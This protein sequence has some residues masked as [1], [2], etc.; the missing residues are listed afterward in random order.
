M[1]KRFF[2]FFILFLFVLSSILP[3]FPANAQSSD[4][5]EENNSASLIPEGS[6]Y[7]EGTVLVTMA[8][9]DGTPLA[10]EGRTSFDSHISVDKSYD[11]G[12][13]S[14]FA[15]SQEQ[16]DFLSDKTLYV[17]ELSSS[18]Y[19]TEELIRKMEQKAYVMYA[20]PDYE[21]Y[22]NTLDNDPYED[23]Q[24]YLD[25][26]R[27]S[28]TSTGISF[29]TS[30]SKTKS[31]TP[32]I[33]IMDTGIDY[34]HED[35]A[36][37]M[38]VNSNMKL[39]GI[40]GYDFIENTP[41]CMD[42]NG[43]GTHCAGVVA[44]VSGNQKGISGISNARLMALKIFDNDGKTTNSKIFDALNYLVQAK[45]LGVNVVAVNCSWGGGTSSSLMPSLI[46]QL[47]AS[48]TLF[49]FASGNDGID[50]NSNTELTCPY[51]LYLGL[52]GENRNY[53]IITGASDINDNPTDFSDYGANDVDLFAPGEK[54]LSTYITDT[55]FP[56]IYDETTE[57]SL[58]AEHFTF[59]TVQDMARLYTSSDLG[60]EP[61]V[62]ASISLEP[63][64]DY[65]SRND[66]GTLKWSLDYGRPNFSAKSSYLYLD[67]TDQNLDMEDTYYV[68]MLFGS[69]DSDGHFSWSHVVKTSSGQPGTTDN[70]FYTAP[71]GSIYFKII[72]LETNGKLSGIS[73]YYIDDIGIS[74]ANP[75]TSLFGRYEALNGTSMAAPMVTGAVA[76]LSEIYPADSATDRRNRLL[77][78]VRPSAGTAS[79]C[80]TGGVLDLTNMD[81][82]V[83]VPVVQTPQTTEGKTDSNEKN[84][85]NS[86]IKVSK[87]K[88]RTS[89]KT[90]QAGKR[91]KLT[92][93]ITPSNASSKKVKWSSSNKKWASVS[94]KGIITAKK[95]GR[96]HT[97][98][99][100]AAATDGSRKKASV[101]IR[102]KK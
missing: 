41:Y 59:D 62:D 30:R 102:I 23:E 4:T 18:F 38:W 57:S 5:A 40:H 47:G 55:Y 34:N 97:V 25:G 28:G 80:R 68:S 12:D 67:V 17:S 36:E 53:I 24:W 95:K 39:P 46:K 20:E 32:V 64:M 58:T 61:G 48:G 6:H 75:D 93:A 15:G 87:I 54:I 16:K 77:G 98:T 10:K 49:V 45:S 86:K 73:H 56:G 51:D 11:F 8:A 90:I 33:A 66:S 43:H 42:T 22:L 13:A 99:I 3:V 26:G 44:A 60:L 63:T 83:P 74:K 71:D 2:S 101:K 94:T 91:L 19:T 96:G 52:N 84:T 9:P 37:H 70:R 50:H 69:T 89:K 27:F 14:N 88:I 81:S 21:Q 65:R 78:C 72:G 7:V 1:K 79:K 92:A 100:T 29:S 35:L 31:G 82:Y 76:L 85:Q